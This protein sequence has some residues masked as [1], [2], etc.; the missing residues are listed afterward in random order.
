MGKD[1]R[2]KIAIQ[3]QESLEKA[4]EGDPER[5]YDFDNAVEVNWKDGKDRKI[6]IIPTNERDG[7]GIYVYTDGLNTAR[8]GLSTLA[9]LYLHEG[10]EKVIIKDK[11]FL[12]ALRDKKDGKDIKLDNTTVK[13]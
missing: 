2:M 11:R 13:V 4:C 5:K 6:V 9:S 3:V 1:E 12:D 10:I 7:I 8:I